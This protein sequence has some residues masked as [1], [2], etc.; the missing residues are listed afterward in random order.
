MSVGSVDFQDP[1]GDPIGVPNLRAA[2]DV[3]AWENSRWSLLGGQSGNPCSPHFGDLLEPWD[4]G[5]G[6]GIAWSPD[7][8]ERRAKATLRL[9][10]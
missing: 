3:G 2:I 10:S 7:D 1:L 4:R 5:Q 9:S 8:V 6:V